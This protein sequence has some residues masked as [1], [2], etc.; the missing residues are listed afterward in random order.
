[1]FGFVV[2]AR[3]YPYDYCLFYFTRQPV[4]NLY[5]FVSINHIITVMKA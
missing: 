5:Q 2:Y 1:M 4:N 3:F